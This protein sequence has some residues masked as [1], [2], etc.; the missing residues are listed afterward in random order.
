MTLRQ[1][2]PANLKE[3]Y[4]DVKE[5]IARA[6]QRSG[7]EASQIMLV[8]VSKYSGVDEIRELLALGHHDFGESQVQQLTQRA[9]MM[10]EY[11]ARQR[12]MP[13]ASEAAASGAASGAVG[14]ASSGAAGGAGSGA[15][16]GANSG[17]GGLAGGSAAVVSPI[18]WHMI[19]HLQR[20]KVRKVIELTRLVHSV[21]SL[22][23]AEE[24]QAAAL[25]T[26]A[27]VDVLVQV[28]CSGES[29]KF[30]CAPAACKHLVD[31]I[32][33]MVHVRVRGLMTMAAPTADADGSRHC[34]SRLRDLYEEILAQGYGE[35]H[36]D[37]LSMGMSGDFE[38]A[39]ECGSNLVRIGSAIFGSADPST[40]SDASESGGD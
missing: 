16:G 26:D 28:N 30:G 34:F 33:T 35:K 18:R 21:E 4:E 31:Q 37:L 39:I 38:V 11:F 23:L 19:G 29:S 1:T 14:G 27:T 9:A 32:N 20:N 7:R 15:I 8:A 40:P 5:R 10:D 12:R 2:V 22:R 3:R 25:R 13:G 36:F 17:A 6:A 24:I